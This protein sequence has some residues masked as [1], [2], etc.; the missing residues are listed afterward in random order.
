MTDTEINKFVRDPESM[1]FYQQERIILDVT[2]RI[3]EAMEEQRINRVQLAL[4][5]GKSKGYISQLLDGSANMTLRT[6]SDVFLALGLIAFVHAK[7]VGAFNQSRFTLV[8]DEI[9]WSPAAGEAYSLPPIDSCTTFDS[10][11]PLAA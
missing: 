5:L 7:P 11:N 2:E 4:K 1:R 9:E 10:S 3:C 6:M 8:H